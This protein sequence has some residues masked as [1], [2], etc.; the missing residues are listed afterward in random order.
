MSLSGGEDDSVVTMV[1]MPR[2]VK[3]QGPTEN[4]R[5]LGMKWSPAEEAPRQKEYGIGP[6]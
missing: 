1:M 4:S 6:S 2:A 3:L 5:C